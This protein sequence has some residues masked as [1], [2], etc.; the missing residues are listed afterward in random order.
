MYCA[1][2]YVVVGN[3]ESNAMSVREGQEHVADVSVMVRLRVS[4]VELVALAGQ[5]RIGNAI[6]S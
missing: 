3:A 4:G 2:R 1:T 6:G 5:A